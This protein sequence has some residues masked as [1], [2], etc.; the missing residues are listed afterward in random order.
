M[1]DADRLGGDGIG[2]ESG[3]LGDGD[4]DFDVISRNVGPFEGERESERRSC[5]NAEEGST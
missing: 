5:L 1:S 4:V 2:G 3:E